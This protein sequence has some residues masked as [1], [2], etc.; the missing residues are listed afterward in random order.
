MASRWKDFHL[1]LGLE[2]GVGL[3]GPK[4]TPPAFKIQGKAKLFLA[5]TLRGR[6]GRENMFPYLMSV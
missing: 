5:K 2:Q 4:G 3:D 6:R 1:G